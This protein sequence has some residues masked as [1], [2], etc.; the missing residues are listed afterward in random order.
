MKQLQKIISGVLLV[1][2][3]YLC[4]GRIAAASWRQSIPTITGR[5][6]DPTGLVTV[7]STI[8]YSD[9]NNNLVPARYARIYLFDHDISGG[10]DQ[11]LTAS[12]NEDGF[13]QFPSFI[14]DDADD[15][16]D[17]NRLLDLYVV[18]ETYYII[19]DVSGPH[20]VTDLG[21]QVYS[22]HSS[23]Q[24]NVPDGYVIINSSITSSDQTRR[25]MWIFQDIRNIWEFVYDRTF[26]H[27]NPGSITG[28]WED[29]ADCGPDEICS[30]HFW[31]GSGGP[32]V[33]IAHENTDSAGYGRA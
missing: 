25:A 32:Y 15:P 20:L 22:W 24:N 31:G 18:W 2:G 11:L 23:I 33:F 12:T 19:D 10:D 4:T 27:V 30:S 8:T 6:L 5:L 29:G 7:R 28:I 26:P 1:I 21:G 14:N 13:V 3:V 16:S 9:R 17:P